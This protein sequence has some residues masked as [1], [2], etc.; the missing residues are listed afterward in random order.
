MQFST[1]TKMGREVF[2]FSP[3]N[4]FSLGLY[5]GQELELATI[6]GL[7]YRAFHCIML[8]VDR[9]PAGHTFK[10][11]CGSNCISD[12]ISVGVASP[13]DSI[14]EKHV[15]IVAQRGKSIRGTLEFCFIQIDELLGAWCRGPFRV[16]VRTEHYTFNSIASNLDKLR[17]IPGIATQQDALVTQLAS[18]LRQQRRFT[19]VP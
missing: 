2:L 12:G 14:Y 1:K 6:Y 4:L 7:N 19:V 16:I 9:D 11:L 8:I 18:L 15:G 13:L 5:N 3:L 17:S 10:L